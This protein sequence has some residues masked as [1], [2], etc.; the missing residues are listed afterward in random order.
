MSR[1]LV[2]GFALVLFATPIQAAEPPE[3]LL[4][5]TTQLY[6]RWDGVTPHK[7]VYQASVWGS[8]WNSPTGDS[9]R[10]LLAKGPKLLG[11]NLLADPLLDGKPPEE[12]RAIHTDLKNAEKLV[13]LIADKGVLV[14]AEVRE[15]RPT[16]K[17]FGK[18]I[19]GLLGGGGGGGAAARA[20][21]AT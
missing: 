13:E 19:G 20:Y 8:V 17:G 11:S 1:Y 2:C 3:R 21:C 16:L 4:S 18:A 15:P 12:L 7:A 10:A 5:P 6:L 14:A 9:I